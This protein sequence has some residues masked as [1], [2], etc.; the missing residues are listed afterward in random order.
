MFQTWQE[1]GGPSHGG[2][3]AKEDYHERKERISGKVLSVTEDAIEIEGYG[4]IP[5]SE[6]SMYIRFTGF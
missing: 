2:R 3:Q 6:I 5:V 4:E 1:P